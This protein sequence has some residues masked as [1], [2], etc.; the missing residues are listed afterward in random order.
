MGTHCQL[1]KWP[2]WTE[3]WLE[4]F[5][6]KAIFDLLFVFIVIQNKCGKAHGEFVIP[7]VTTIHTQLHSNIPVHTPIHTLTLRQEQLTSHANKYPLCL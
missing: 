7:I 1:S 3:R 5:I 6:R 2:M 4:D